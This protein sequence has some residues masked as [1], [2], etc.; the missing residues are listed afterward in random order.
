M[1]NKADS[2]AQTEDAST[3]SFSAFMGTVPSF[4]EELTQRVSNFFDTIDEIH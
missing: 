3:G 2:V 4:S 1:A